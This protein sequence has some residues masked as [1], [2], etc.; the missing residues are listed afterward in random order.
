MVDLYLMA[1][2]Y[3]S[4]LNGQAFNIGGGIVNSLSIIELL[5]YLES[6]LKIELNFKNIEER[7]SDQKIF[8]ADT[9]K[10]QAITSWFPKISKTEGIRKNLEWVDSQINK[11]GC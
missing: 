2:E 5:S 11:T 8:I 7:V 4:D 10:I 6:T 9:T 3:I 1:P